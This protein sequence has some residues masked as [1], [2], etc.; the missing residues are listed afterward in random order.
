M[1]P[2]FI[3]WSAVCLVL[4]GIGIWAW[5]AKTPVGFYAG[6]ET[7]KVTD[8]RKYNRSVAWLWFGYAG[9]IELIG[10]ALFLIKEKPA[11]F[12]LLV[13]GTVAATILLVLVYFKIEKRY[14]QK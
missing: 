14:R 4:I 2:G 3:I 5:N 13:L 7:P 1:V 11:A 6:V 10:R 12:L 8:V 9:L